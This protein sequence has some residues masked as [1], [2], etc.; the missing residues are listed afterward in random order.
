WPII[1]QAFLF[2]STK[3]MGEGPPRFQRTLAAVRSRETCKNLIS[4]FKL[5]A[6]LTNDDYNQS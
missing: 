1:L 3:Q 4:V 6:E 5:P 2:L